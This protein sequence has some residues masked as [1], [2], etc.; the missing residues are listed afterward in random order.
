MP[1][2]CQELR[3]MSD[4]RV[5]FFLKNK[6]MN[7]SESI[8]I[9]IAGEAGQGIE[10]ASE[11]VTKI[12]HYNNY[13][14]FSVNEYMSRI[15]G[16]SNSAL[17]K[18]SS[19]KSPCFSKRIDLLFA[20]DNKAFEHLKYR[21]SDKTI[22]F[23]LKKKNFYVVGYI[24]ALFKLSL[25]DCLKFLENYFEKLIKIENNL[26]DFKEGYDGGVVNGGNNS[27]IQIEIP[28][29]RN[30][31]ENMFISVNDAL[32][33]GCIAGGCNFV[34]FY[35]MS[36]ATFLQ[37][38]LTDN[39]EYFGIISRQA[40]DEICVM[41]MALGAWYSGAR[42]IACSSGGGFDLMCEATSLAGII[43][44]PVVINIAQRPGPATGLPTRTEQ[45][46]LNLALYSGHGEFP[47]IVYAP[48]T[49]EDAY[50]VGAVAFD[51]ADKF[52]VPVFILTDQALLE[53]VYSCNEFMTDLSPTN[54]FKTSNSDYKRYKLGQ[55][56]VSPRAIPNFGEG[57][58]CVD[59]DE[60]DE[61]GYITEDFDMRVK[62]VD[63]RLSKFNL[64]SNETLAPYYIGEEDYKILII[65]WGSNFHVI[66]E[67][68]K[69]KKDYALVH[70]VQ[71]YPIDKIIV[72]Y[73][74]KAQKVI[75][76]EQNATGQFAKLLKGEL[77]LD[78]DEKLLK[79][80]GMPFSVEEVEAFLEGVNN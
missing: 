76:V 29:N 3:H 36:P 68:I 14:V 46:D 7:L 42:A 19:Q 6:G 41:N 24:C 70:F 16:G 21:I 63:K 22:S 4:V 57:V 64:I 62:M 20:L 33:I 11:I 65:S 18:V 52:Q 49:I 50:K 25:E 28:A 43:E 37:S 69:N 38:F 60:H 30:H 10:T 75:I 78:V 23:D 35:P 73:V 15:R 61:T 40:E 9:V 8:N 39:A 48:A 74:K 80:S 31:E 17:I 1:L 58:V 79:Y 67:A 32:G 12:L 26:A 45:G 72:D 53:S 13:N 44:S 56:P 34:P 47:R 51:M 66:K 77:G 54:Y 5:L 71:V 59:S 55:N 2:R 27:N